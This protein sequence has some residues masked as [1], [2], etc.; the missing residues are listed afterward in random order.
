MSHFGAW[1]RVRNASS[2]NRI[3]I[4][5]FN[6]L[7]SLPPYPKI[8]NTSD[9]YTLVYPRPNRNELVHTKTHLNPA[10]L[11]ADKHNDIR[12]FTKHF[13]NGL[14]GQSVT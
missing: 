10:L 9:Q 1:N 11:G 7:V 14:K 3:S 4:T 6:S 12:K 2:T 8:T 13:T 5:A